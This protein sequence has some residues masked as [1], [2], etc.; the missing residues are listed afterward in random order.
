MFDGKIRIFFPGKTK[1][2]I[3]FKGLCAMFV[4][5]AGK[6]E[7]DQEYV[8]ASLVKVFGAV[9]SQIESIINEV[10]LCL[11]L[12]QVLNVQVRRYW[13]TLGQKDQ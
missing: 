8:P 6:C 13:I 2:T 11:F 3:L 10:L 1:G 9:L 5:L 4:L 12:I 7:A